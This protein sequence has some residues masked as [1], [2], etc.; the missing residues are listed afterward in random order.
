LGL[1]KISGLNE[2][3]V[4]AKKFISWL[5][6][7][8]CLEMLINRLSKNLLCLFNVYLNSGILL[9]LML[10]LLMEVNNSLVNYKGLLLV[11][12]QILFVI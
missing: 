3:L 5:F 6:S 4:F 9:E 1:G 12:A 10:L 2:F 7:S 11:F 8:N